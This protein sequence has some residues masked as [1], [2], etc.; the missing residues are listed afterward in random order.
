MPKAYRV[1]SL[2]SCLG[3]VSE[4]ILAKRLSYLV[5]ISQL[6][7]P[8]QIGGR[9]TKSA[10]DA[11]LLLIN[12]VETNRQIRRVTST[13]FLDVK[14]AFDHVSRNQ[15]L[16]QIKKIRLPTSLIS[17]VASFLDHRVL[18][19]SFNGETESFKSA[20][21]GIPQGSPIS[22]MLFL[23]YISD[24]FITQDV[25]CISYMDD[26]AISTKS[27]SLRKNTKTLEREVAKIYAKGSQNAIQFD[28][29]KTELMHF[30]RSKKADTWHVRLP[31]DVVIAPTQ[32]VR[33]LGIW[34]DPSL[35]FRSHINIRAAQA[36][37]TFYRITRYS[38]TEVCLPVEQTKFNPPSQPGN[39]SDCFGPQNHTIKTD[40]KYI[41]N[42]SDGSSLEQIKH[43]IFP[44][45]CAELPFT[46]HRGKNPK[47]I[48]AAHH[49]EEFNNTNWETTTFIYTDASYM[50]DRKGVG[51]SVVATDQKGTIMEKLAI[52]TGDGNL[53]YNGELEGIT[54]GIEYASVVMTRLK[55]NRHWRVM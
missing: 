18:Q 38:N 33:W 1:I 24:L 25:R 48:V 20:E 22:P 43:Y 14:G 6:L 52:N 4:R 3:K 8:T 35:K 51:V 7:D 26:I 30:T 10:V 17:W 28:L 21:T 31:D 15:I 49:Q 50:E 29:L 2:L 42:P 55:C 54:Q 47:E 41:G 40:K 13:L 5:E 32:L 23:I 16:D 44:P 9:L 39:E 53:V 11:A 34:F 37:Q 36:L 46:V 12:E 45:W 27:T 19:L